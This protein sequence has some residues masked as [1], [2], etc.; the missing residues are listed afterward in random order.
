MKNTKC[1]AKRLA[2]ATLIFAL[3]IAVVTTLL[4]FSKTA[5]AEETD[6]TQLEAN[7]LNANR[8]SVGTLSVTQNGTE[9]S[10]LGYSINAVKT[11]YMDVTA[12]KD[13]SPVFETNWLKT[14]IEKGTQN[15][16]N[17]TTTFAVSDK[18]FDSVSSK[19]SD[20]LKFSADVTGGYKMFT[21]S[22]S[23]GFSTNSGIN[24][25][26]AG[27][28]YFYTLNSSRK[29]YTYALP[30]YLTGKNTYREHLSAQY[31]ANLSNLFAGTMSASDFFDTYGTHVIAKGIYGGKLDIFYSAV[32]NKFDI[33]NTYFKSVDEA[34]SANITEKIKVSE[35]MSFSISEAIG[36][37]KEDFTERFSINAYGGN[38]FEASSLETVNSV[39]AIG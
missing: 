24:Y 18:S 4:S 38:A 27:S 23:A 15:A 28:Q 30:E 13:G 8:P 5:Y 35:K 34:V 1:L 2:Y 29:E 32:S 6:V 25:S 17:Q 36:K 19:Y 12:V 20:E 31:I 9:V 7:V 11:T 10:G 37:S 22:L 3:A 26:S 16:V 14:Q 33:G 39:L 21:G